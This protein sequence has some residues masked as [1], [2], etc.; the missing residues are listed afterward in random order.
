MTERDASSEQSVSCMGRKGEREGGSVGE[1]AE[2]VG[3]ARAG[4]GGVTAMILRLCSVFCT[5]PP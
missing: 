1:V 5:K 4:R 2:E 3:G